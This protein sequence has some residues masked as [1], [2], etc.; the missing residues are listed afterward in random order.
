MRVTL[1]PPLAGNI[2]VS[3]SSQTIN[4]GATG[5]TLTASPPSGGDGTYSYQWQ[6]SPNN[7]TWSNISGANGSTYTPAG[8]RATTYYR[9]VVTSFDYSVTSSTATVTVVTPAIAGGTIANAAQTINFNTTPATISCSAASGGC[10]FLGYSYQWQSSTNGTSWNNISGATGQH[11][12]PG[13]LITTTYYRR[14]VT[15]NGITVYSTNTAK[16]TVYPQVR[17]S[18]SPSGKAINYNTSPGKLTG[19]AT[20]GNNTYTYQWQSSEN[21]TTWSNIPNAN[22]RDYTPGNLIKT[23]YYRLIAYSNGAQGVSNTATITVYPQVLCSVSPSGKAINYNTS[24][25]KLT[26][27]ASGGTNAYTYQWQSS[28]N[29][30]TWSNIPNANGRDYTPGNLIKTT[31]YRLI[32][33]SNGAQG[34]SNTATITV[35]PQVRCSIS[36]S[37]KAINYNTSP[38]KLTGTASGGTNTYTYQWQSSENGTTWSNILNANGADYTPGNLIKTTYYR[39]ITYSNGA[40]G[41]S[42]TATITVYPQLTSSISPASQS[43]NYNT[44]PGT[45]TNT[46]GGGNGTYTYQWQ[47]STNNSTWTNIPGATSQNYTPGNLTGTTYYRV[48]TTSNNASV[49]SNTATITVY[50]EL[51][52]SINP[53]SAVI[54]YDSTAG[55]LINTVSGGTGTYS[56]QWQRSTDGSNWSNI[57][58]A[59]SQ[60]YAPGRLTV[61]TYYRVITNSNGALDTSNIAAIYVYGQLVASISPASISI[62]Y[63]SLP[64]QLTQYRNGGNGSYTY[65]WQSSSD[66]VS[67]NDIDGATSR[68]Y[69]P[70]RLTDTTY[71]RVITSSNGTTVTSNTSAVIVYG[72]LTSSVTPPSASISYDSSPGQ[73]TNTVS[74]GNGTYSYQWQRSTDNI[75]W[76]NIS[77][78]VSQHY[79][80][81]KLTSTAY[82]RVV[83]ASNGATATSNAVMVIVRAPQAGSCTCSCLKP[84]FDYLI[85]SQ[86]LF[87]AATDNTLTAFLVQDAIDA[88]YPV[89]FT[90]CEVLA[91]NINKPFYALTTEATAVTYKAR[92]GDCEVSLTSTSG[93]AIDLYGLKNSVCNDNVALY[94]NASEQLAA[95][96][97]LE[98]CYTCTTV[99]SGICYSTVTDTIINPYLYSIAGN[100]RPFRTYVYYGP[101][102]ETGFAEGTNIRRDGT[103]GAFAPF[104]AIQD[105]GAMT[106]Q[107]DESR[108]VWNM[109]STLFNRKGFELENKD[110]LGRFN[111][112]L[113]GYDHALP[114]AV[115]QN[116]RYRESAFEG[117]EDYY[118]EPVICDAACAG[119]R[120]FDF[121]SYKN[122]LD[123]T[124]H[125][126]GKYS[127]RLEAGASAGIS[128]TPVPADDNVFGLT[129]NT[130]LNNCAEGGQVLKSIKANA[131]AL[132]PGFSPLAGKQLLVSAWVK[133]EQDCNCVSYANSQVSIVVEQDSGNTVVIAK[134]AG[135]IIEGWQRIEQVVNVPEGTERIS[136]N[137]QSTGATRVYFDDIRVH[138]YN[139]NMRSFVYNPVN[140]RLMAEL[141]ENNY[142]TFYEYDDDGTLIRLKQETERG[143]KTIKETRSALLKE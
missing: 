95:R 67:W 118:F 120:N 37:V 121:S 70:G 126:T 116:G 34:V 129:I 111:A 12:A 102:K 142:A 65:Q 6:S 5:T 122:N 51:I 128:A 19:T 64:G 105:N 28:E 91:S 25:G 73:L 84:L 98:A 57:P 104:W 60:N 14:A 61:T 69:T 139:A 13:N 1:V 11:Y 143:V 74:G 88:G 133:E 85:A 59:S 32:G 26:G 87:I 123:T 66:N 21:G 79:T 90:G 94:Y 35:Y 56:Y 130:A 24:P 92:V 55:E 93:S 78:A 141:D 99:T 109:E 101:R 30:T 106:P 48:V 43:I 33:Y 114:V 100:W 138:P 76:S 52:T 112:G 81:G 63:N 38:G 80:P 18:I 8:L 86:R 10:S 62:N 22:G 41:I 125:H 36:P 7:S 83:T 96:L 9:V 119:G 89:S 47:V 20:G 82:F 44:A 107:Y 46:R 27:T 103:F 127:L 49:T 135:G 137:L 117:F 23:T 140:L 97:R 39:L 132:L 77:D 131:D 3:P 53:V 115:V 40:Q 124:Q 136:I 42:N 71:Y 50:P 4:C 15:N 113:Y 2:T 72:K 68:D 17:C 134:P 75:N 45:L 108:W 31:Y 29:G 58:G 16:V 54:N 110:P